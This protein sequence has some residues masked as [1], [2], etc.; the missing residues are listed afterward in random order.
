MNLQVLH[1]YK[2]FNWN[3]I[4][5]VGADDVDLLGDNTETVNKTQGPLI[6]VK[7]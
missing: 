5:Y 6:T 3:V 1:T 4:D 7:T 2:I